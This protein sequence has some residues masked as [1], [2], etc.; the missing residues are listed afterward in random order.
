M[1]NLNI[2]RV[3]Q[4]IAEKVKDYKTMMTRLAPGIQAYLNAYNTMLQ[5]DPADVRAAV[6][7]S[8]NAGVPLEDKWFYPTGL[9]FPNREA[10][11]EW[12]EGMLDRKRV[13]SVDGSQLDAGKSIGVPVA[14]AR[15]VGVINTYDGVT[16]PVTVD[17]YVGISPQ[18][19]LENA[20]GITKVRMVGPEIDY[21][22]SKLESKVAIMLLHDAAGNPTHLDTLLFDNTFL[23]SYLKTDRTGI[24]TK[25]SIENLLQM[26]NK[27]QTAEVPLLGVVDASV[28]KELSFTLQ[29]LDP[30]GQLVHIPPVPDAFLLKNHLNLFDRTCVFV[31]YRE[32]VKKYVGTMNGVK[33]DYRDQVGFFY[34]RTH[35]FNPLRVEFPLW[36]YRAGRVDELKNILCALSVAGKG[37]PHQLDYCHKRCVLRNPERNFFLATLQKECNQQALDYTL[38]IKSFRKT[39]GR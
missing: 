35:S 25:P 27:T 24:Y 9:D 11:F 7:S 8:D 29:Q 30:T 20:G 4:I 21:A 32:I 15:A 22:R 17:E 16:R 5:Q 39:R 1:L 23:L 10:M 28:A 38:S 13:G 26:F 6:G 14:L 31:S 34:V 19:C 3:K 12:A 37:Y 18:D 33:L 2:S 36:I